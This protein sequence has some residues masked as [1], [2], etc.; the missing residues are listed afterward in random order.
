MKRFFTFLLAVLLV[1]S[2]C[3]CNGTYGKV[4][5]KEPISLPEDGIVEEALLEQIKK[6]NEIVIFTGTSNGL[7]YEW[8]IF[9]SELTEVKSVNLS[10]SL[11]LRLAASEIIGIIDTAIGDMNDG[12]RPNT[13]TQRLPYPEYIRLATPD[14]KPAC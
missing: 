1:T 13:G 10:L 4:N 12:T 6:E 9:G 8:K 5:L 2:L 14:E 3:A 11:S 7:D